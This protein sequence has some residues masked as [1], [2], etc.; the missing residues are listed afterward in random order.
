MNYSKDSFFN[1]EAL[2]KIFD[3]KPET[4]RQWIDKGYVTPK[5]QGRRGQAH[6]FVWNDLLRIALFRKFYDLGIE[7]RVSAKLSQAAKDDD[8]YEVSSEDGI[9][10]VFDASGQQAKTISVRSF[11]ENE[12]PFI[13][14]E[15]TEA[16]FIINAKKLIKELEAKIEGL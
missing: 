4:I 3:K 1:K 5:E 7:A 14:K 2:A 13:I 11:D 12:V 10:F 9:F 15:E 16:V 6:L 8:W